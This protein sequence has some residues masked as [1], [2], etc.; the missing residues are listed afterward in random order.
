MNNTDEWFNDMAF[1]HVA[2]C[3]LGR[4]VLQIHGSQMP[5]LNASM[6]KEFFK[7]F[8]R[9]LDLLLAYSRSPISTSWFSPIAVLFK[10][11]LS[12]CLSLLLPMSHDRWDMDSIRLMHRWSLI[13]LH[14]LLLPSP[15]SSRLG[16]FQI[17]S[18]RIGAPYDICWVSSCVFFV[19]IV[20]H[21]FYANP[22]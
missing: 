13:A 18:S 12:S 16:I 8:D 21:I 4:Q 11:A 5:C 1:R 6:K 9:F 15:Q 14:L 22:S 7:S 10:T 19:A 17:D 20:F 2:L 3:S